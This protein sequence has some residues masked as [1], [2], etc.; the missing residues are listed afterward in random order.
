MKRFKFDQ[1]YY[2]RWYQNDD[3]RTFMKEE[4]PAIV[5]FV[6]SYLDY[7]ELDVKSV[8]DVGCGLGYWQAGIAA[9]GKKIEY[10]GLEISDYLCD[11]YPWQKGSIVDYAPGRQ[12]DLVVCQSVLQYMSRKECG[13]AIR[14]IGALCTE[15][16]YVE[17]PTARDLKEACLPQRTDMSVY[18]RQ[19]QWY[20]TRLARDFLNMG[21]GLFVKRA[22]ESSYYELWTLD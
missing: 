14:N 20:R 21:G 2:E 18:R 17:I 5:S 6:L 3:T 7:L 22:S 16:L 9:T 11:R 8:L 13:Q 12:Y 10:T 1:A 19:A 15:A 4:T